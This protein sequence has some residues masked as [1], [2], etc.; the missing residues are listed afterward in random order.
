MMAKAVIYV[1]E[2]VIEANNASEANNAPLLVRRGETSVMAHSVTILDGLN[3]KMG[4]ITYVKGRV[5]AVEIDT[6]AG[7][8]INTEPVT[9]SGAVLVPQESAE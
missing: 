7:I 9:A 4:I 5:P 8:L 1:S 6:E 3:N 2:D